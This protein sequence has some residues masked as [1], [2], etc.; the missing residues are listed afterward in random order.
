[1]SHPILERH[2]E[3]RSLRPLYLFYGDE[4]FLMERA[5]RRLERA[6]SEKSGE[7]ATRV[8]Q[9]A[10]EIS[11]EDF[12]AQARVATLWGGGQLLVLRRANAYPAAA[13]T[14][15]TAYLEHPAPH[16][17]VVLMAP[18]LKTSEVQKHAVFGRLLKNEAALG[19]FRLREGELLPWLTR[20]ARRLGKTLSPAAA[21][22]LLEVVGDNLSELHQE[23]NKLVLYA[24]AEATLTPQQVNQ[25]ATHSRS[26]NIFALV[27]ALGEASPQRRLTALNH[28][29]ELGE[30]PARILAMLAR[31]LRLLIRYREADPQAAPAD[32]AKELRLAPGLVKKVGR[33]AHQFSLKALKSHLHL[34]HQADLAIKTSAA[35]PR[36]W[37]EW[38]LLQMGPG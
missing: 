35:S 4:E 6:L 38:T 36:V 17:L 11:L 2:L 30:P 22:R 10:P 13:L 14:L 1:M 8:V 12:F 28:L 5:L 21:Q 34:L 16:S 29:L 24:G 25:L 19:F 7:A 31:Q 32:L 33:Q 9:E 3:R 20:E 15:V 23:L 18:G 27:D 37:L 26:Y